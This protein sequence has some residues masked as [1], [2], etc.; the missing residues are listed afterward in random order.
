M[1]PLVAAEAV[2]VL[3]PRVADS[4]SNKDGVVAIIFVILKRQPWNQSLSLGGRPSGGRSKQ[5][6]GYLLS[7]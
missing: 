7:Q 6:N 1:P 2:A 5:Q 3:A 4:S